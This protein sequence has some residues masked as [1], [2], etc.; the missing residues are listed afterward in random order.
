MTL[1]LELRGVTKAYGGA[2]PAVDGIDMNVGQGEFIALLGPSGCGKTTTLRMV[3][4]FV[5]PTAGRIFLRGADITELPPHR[6][7]MGM[8]FQSYALFPH[9]TVRGNIEFGL[10]S[11]GVSKHEMARRVAGALDLVGLAAYEGR[12]PRELSGGQQQRVAVARVLALDPKLLLFDEPLSNLD[13]KLRGQMRHEIRT[14]Q[15]AV[16][17]T[18]LFVTHD[19]DEAL[20]MADRIVV[21]NRGRIEQIGTPAD[22]Y[23]RPQTQFVADFIGTTNFLSG[24]VAIGDNN[25]PIFRTKSGLRVEF[26]ATALSRD[27]YNDTGAG[28]VSI[29][30]EN[31]EFATP[32][33]PGTHSATISDVTRLASIIEYSLTLGVG[34]EIIVRVQRRAGLEERAVGSRVDLR[35][36]P[37]D[38]RFFAV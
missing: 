35:W 17:V 34:D 18:T 1:D 2:V 9:M 32:G 13:A 5:S 26:D 22:V 28:V 4:G 12:Y 7:D 6:R 33:A 3:A 15:K 24:S 27:T 38:V 19:Q 30:P 20:T 25:Q 29:R 16:G 23:D 10:R 8:V 11:H 14:L 31:I 36:R 37:E 21:L